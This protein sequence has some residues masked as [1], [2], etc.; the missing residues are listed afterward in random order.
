V[1]DRFGIGYSSLSH[2]RR[3]PF[4]KIKIDRSVTHGLADQQ[5]CRT[6]VR[7]ITGL[8]RSLGMKVVADG[9]ETIQQLDLLRRF[10]CAGAQGNLFSLP[11]SASASPELLTA[12]ASTPSAGTPRPARRAD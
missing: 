8:G 11:V 12:D 6:A 9:V 1:M 3:F 7:A 2:L 10:G 5:D 4:D